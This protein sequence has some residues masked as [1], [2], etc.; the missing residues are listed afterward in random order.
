MSSM[1]NTTAASLQAILCF[2]DPKDTPKIA[3]DNDEYALPLIEKIKS[4]VGQRNGSQSAYISFTDDEKELLRQFN[5]VCKNIR[6]IF[7]Q[8]EYCTQNRS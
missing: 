5:G 7:D 1:L 2:I 6:T 4:Y 8:L 3:F